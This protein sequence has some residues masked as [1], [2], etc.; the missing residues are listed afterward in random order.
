MSLYDPNEHPTFAVADI[1][2]WARTKPA[3][4]VYRF[5]DINNCAVSQFGRETGRDWLV[6]DYASAFAPRGVFIAAGTAPF[7]FGGFADRLEALAK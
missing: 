1:L 4:E 3:G 5:T 6:G 7:T 2:A